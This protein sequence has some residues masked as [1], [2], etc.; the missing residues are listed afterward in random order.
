MR[1]GFLVFCLAIAFL[2]P[3]TATVR[4]DWQMAGGDAARTGSSAADPSS[5]PGL[6]WATAVGGPLLGSPVVSRNPGSPWEATVFAVTGGTVTLDAVTATN[7]TLRW[8]SPLSA[9]VPAPWVFRAQGGLATDASRVYA[10]ITAQN[11]SLNE[12]REVLVAPLRGGGAAGRREL[13]G[14]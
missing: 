12:W 10:L 9:Y 4:A 2:I 1:R 3:A 8:S 11:G 6:L 14:G 13:R 5:F 7:G